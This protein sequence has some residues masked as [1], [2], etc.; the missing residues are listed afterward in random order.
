[1]SFLNFLTK[2]KPNNPIKYINGKIIKYGFSIKFING[3]GL[4]ICQIDNE[5]TVNINKPTFK[6]KTT[7]LS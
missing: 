5:K 1:M 6:L 7:D 2:N 3:A 4:T